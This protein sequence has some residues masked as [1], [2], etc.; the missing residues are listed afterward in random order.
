MRK[1]WIISGLLLSLIFTL[2]GC[3]NDTQL[4]DSKVTEDTALFV[5]ESETETPTPA[6][7]AE[8][9][10]QIESIITEMP[11]STTEKE[12]ESSPSPVITEETVA[13][14][15]PATPKPENTDPPKNREPETDKPEKPQSTEEITPPKEDKPTETQPPEPEN[16]KPTQEV[17]NDFDITEW[18][19]FTKSYAQSIGLSLDSTATECWDNP[20]TANPN[21][22]NLKDDIM[23]RLNRYK[24]TEGFTAVWV[25]VEKVSDTE[26]ELYIGYA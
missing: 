8:P 16:T 19:E 17:Q 2:N 26:Y 1:K 10:E 23:S 13:T 4:P 12:K 7:I 21:R 9:T 6:E 22:T 3:G 18:V 20:I 11:D 25:W 15:V 14:T 5:S 24:N